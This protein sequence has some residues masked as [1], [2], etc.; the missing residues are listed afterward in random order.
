MDYEVKDIGLADQG[1]RQIEL[2]EMQMKGLMKIRER[3][4]NEK[5]LSGIRVGMALHI[6]KETAALVRT[7]HAGGAEVAITGC[8]PLSTQDDVAAALAEQGFHVYG[9]KGETKEEYYKNL[10]RVLDFRPHVTIDDGCDLVSEIH[11]KRTDLLKEIIGGAEETTTGIIRLRSMEKDNALKYPIIA[12]NDSK[13]K[14]L[15]D[16]Y[17]GTG[18]S[19]I[20]GILRATNILIAGKNFVVSGYGNC[21]KGVAT[22][23]KGMGANVIV[24][25]VDPFKALQAAT[26]GFRVMPMAKAA[27]IGDIFVTVTG[28]KHVLSLDSLKKMKNGAIVANSGHFNIEIDI[29]G[30]EGIA[31]KRKIRPFMDE[32]SFDGKKLFV[33]GEGRLINLAAAEGH[34]SEIMS[35]SFMN[36]CLAVE[37]LVKNKGLEPKVYTL[38]KEVDDMIAKIQLEAMGVE[39]DT[40]TKEQSRYLNSWDEGT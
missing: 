17:I 31:K 32:Y 29:K 20:D 9:W 35:M 2:A 3:F 6:T 11:L 7:L 5:P 22:R 28:D 27:N 38:P 13:T 37:Y 39:I 19:T 24:T 12:V 34:P 40:L 1:K 21:G 14:H 26:D 4:E 18:Q 25:E 16:N 10:N 23:A 15:F 30:L 33:L 8:N 36:Q